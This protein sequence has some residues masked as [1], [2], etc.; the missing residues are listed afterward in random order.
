MDEAI[1][2]LQSI[3]AILEQERSAGNNPTAPSAAPAATFD[4]ASP[5]TGTMQDTFGPPS[6]VV[7][8]ALQSGSVPPNQ[9]VDTKAIADQ[10]VVGLSNANA[11]GGSQ[12]VNVKVQVEVKENGHWVAKVLD[13]AK[14]FAN[15]NEFGNQVAKWA[16]E[17]NKQINQKPGTG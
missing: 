4:V 8:P 11:G 6:D 16:R 14:K 13:I 17:R 1:N 7:A 9:V 15:T 12:E 2:V 3:K 10:V 5:N